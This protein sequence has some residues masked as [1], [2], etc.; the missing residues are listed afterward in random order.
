[1]SILRYNGRVWHPLYVVI[2]AMLG[3][4]S[5]VSLVI[6]LKATAAAWGFLAMARVRRSLPADKDW[7]P[8]VRPAQYKRANKG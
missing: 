4:I 2:G 7:K 6:Q 5:Y 3:V 8:C 1:M